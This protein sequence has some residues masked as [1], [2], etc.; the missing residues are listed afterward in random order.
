MLNIN[1]VHISGNLTRD[2]ELRHL[3]N[4]NPVCNFSMALN[5]KWKKD[6]QETQETTYI[7]CVAFGRRAEAISQYLAKG[8]QIYVEGRLRQERWEDKEGRKCTKIGVV[9]DEFQ[10]GDPPRDKPQSQRGPVPGFGKQGS[11][12]DDSAI[13]D[14]PW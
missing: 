2:P 3:P 12:H 13:D 14:I 11:K 9:V 5:R 7:D 1:K 6:G 4:N 8:R 10:F